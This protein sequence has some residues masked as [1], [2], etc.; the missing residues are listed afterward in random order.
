MIQGFPLEAKREYKAISDPISELNFSATSMLASL[1]ESSQFSWDHEQ[2]KPIRFTHER[3]IFGH[4]KRNTLSF[5]WHKQ[6]IISTHKGKTRYINNELAA[7]DRL[8]FQLQ[9][10]HDL[11]SNIEDKVYRIADKN[12]IK[13]YAFKI[14]GEEVITTALGKLNTTKVKVVRDNNK[15][16]TYVWLARDWH[17]LLARLEQYEN[18]DKKFSLQVTK[19]VIDGK[20]VAGL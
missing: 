9:L 4:S 13:E 18:D 6:E 7:L 2:I 12:K 1:T 8:S 15:R 11:S 19:A 20:R 3:K 17:N 14:I 5:D 10:Q 16:V